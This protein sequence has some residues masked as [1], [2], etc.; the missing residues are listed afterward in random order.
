MAKTR[1]EVLLAAALAA[2][3]ASPDPIDAAIL[4]RL[5]DERALAQYEVLAFQPFDPVRKRAEALVRGSAKERG[6][7][8]D[9]PNVF[10]GGQQWL[11]P[12]AG[13]GSQ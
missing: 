11:K 4:A 5:A 3:R 13:S 2:E 8:S 12:A 6:G 10:E 7:V 1:A 9:A